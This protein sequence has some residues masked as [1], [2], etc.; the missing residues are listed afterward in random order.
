[1]PQQPGASPFDQE[2][3][4]SCAELRPP[5]RVLVLS[6]V[7]HDYIARGIL[8]HAHFTPAVVSDDANQ[9]GWVHER[10]QRFADDFHIP[11]VPGIEQ[12]I[13]QFRPHVAVVSSEAER[14]C[15]LSVRAARAG[16]HIVQDKPMST[17]LTEC[18]RVVEAVV[19]HGVRFLLWNRNLMPAVLQAQDL[20]RQGHLGQL[21]AMHVDFYFAKDA[22]PPKG[23]RAAG[24]P[25]ADWLEALKAA[26]A[27]GADGGIGHRPMGELEVE[28]IYPL[29]YM[30]AIAG[31][32]VREVFARASS[33]VHQLHADHGVDDLA[34]VTLKMSNGIVGS[35]CMG[36]IG[37]AS[38]PDLGEIKLHLIGSEASA[39]ISEP[40]PEVAVYYRGQ[41][42]TEFPHVRV[43]NHNDWLLADD[44]SQ[45]IQTG[46]D[47]CLG[48][49]AGRSIVATVQAA[50]D[51]SRR[52]VPVR[53]RD[54]QGN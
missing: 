42:D 8:S 12:A 22:G 6:V 53:V 32:E 4:M 2:T 25:P 49:A 37:N 51:S 24:D 46:T 20:V 47:T 39:V 31:A 36:R 7:K 41:P 43:A 33:H 28:G 38:H 1:V 5:W 9:A 30:H 27:T 26:H 23:S 11:Y 16:L 45:A 18:D 48:A 13:D 17:S 21:R 15:D 35:I 34:S 19:R 44:F 10:N 52:G 14:H 50:L 40:R 29:A 54:A 3:V